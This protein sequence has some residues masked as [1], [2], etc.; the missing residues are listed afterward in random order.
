MPIKITKITYSRT[1]NLGNYESARVEATAEV[2]DGENPNKV[3][4]K[5]ALWV[6]E[7]A[8]DAGE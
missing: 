5:L 4:A 7:Q 2:Q 8:E 6:E 3:A 1:V